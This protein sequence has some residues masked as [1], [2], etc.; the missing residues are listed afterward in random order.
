VAGDHLGQEDHR[1]KKGEL[2]L[3][4]FFCIVKFSCAT[5]VVAINVTFITLQL[6]FKVGLGLVV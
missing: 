3:E 2:A 5:S 6:N 4:N 1:Q